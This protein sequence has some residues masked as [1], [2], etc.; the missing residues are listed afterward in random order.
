M[1]LP[2]EIRSIWMGIW[3]SGLRKS[4]VGLAGFTLIELL[5]S[6]TILSILAMLAL[7]NF[8]DS[9]IRAKVARTRADMR[10]VTLGLEMYHMDN[11][12][13]VCFVDGGEG[14]LVDRVVVPMSRRLSPI[15]TP[16]SYVSTVPLDVF[17]TLA[18]S[19]GSPLV[20]FDTYD[21]VDVAGLVA[22]GSTKGAG[23]A[24]GAWWRLSSAGP[25]RIQSFGGD[26]AEHGDASQS[27]RMGI[28]YDPTNGVVSAGDI[29]AVG[30]PSQ[31]GLLPSIRRTN[32]YEELFRDV[33][34]K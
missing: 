30:Q 34:A 7:N 4:T 23:A 31:V 25:D 5:V 6:I 8:L 11:N 12:C 29:V 21:Y 13:Y 14:S 27:N 18:T 2:C 26:L 15:T 32:G 1:D 16:I 3:G 22:V 20:F 17:E 24:S 33:P 28:D 19:D 9:T 10:T